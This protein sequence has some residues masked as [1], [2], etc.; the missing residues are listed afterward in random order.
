MGST[1][2]TQQQ[3]LTNSKRGTGGI[4]RPPDWLTLE[5]LLEDKLGKRPRSDRL[6][7]DDAALRWAVRKGLAEGATFRTTIAQAARGMGYP[8]TARATSEELRVKY[9]SNVYRALDSLAEL[10]LLRW[11]GVTWEDGR[12]R[13]LEVELLAP[14]DNDG[15][16][17]RICVM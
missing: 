13:C 9:K 8:A 5:Q 4:P 10:G 14:V 11:G 3:P 6:E 12:M 2:P 7:R 17:T 15:Q 16:R 1:Q